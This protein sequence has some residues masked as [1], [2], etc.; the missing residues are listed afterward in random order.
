MSIFLFLLGCSSSKDTATDCLDLAPPPNVFACVE[1]GSAEPALSLEEDLVVEEVLDTLPSLCGHTVGQGET[2]ASFGLLLS[3]SDGQTRAVGFSI[4]GIAAPE[5]GPGDPVHLK[6]QIVP[7]DWQPD[8]AGITLQSGAG[9]LLA[10]VG[11]AA[12]VDELQLPDGYQIARGASLCETVEDCGTWYS[13]T[14]TLTSGVHTLSLDPGESGDLE[15]VRWFHHETLSD[16]G[17]DH[18]VDWSVASTS[19]GAFIP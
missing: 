17:T 19:L 2:N 9:G 18:C 10:Y 14:V 12:S 16:G 7:G 3:K 13:H 5:L 4:P 15:G 6:A 1:D 8:V 11:G